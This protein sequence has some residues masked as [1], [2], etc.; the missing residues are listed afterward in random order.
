MEQV[1]FPGFGLTLNISKIA[2]TLFGEDVYWYAVLIA[3]GVAIGFIFLV[4]IKGKN[5]IFGIKSD[6][7]FDALLYTVPISIISGRAYYVIFNFETFKHNLLNIFNFKTGGMAIYGSIIGGLLTLIIF[8]KKRKINTLDLVDYIVP[9][10]ALGQSIGRWGNFF[11]VEA[12]GTETK[13][14][15]RMGIIEKGTYI[16]VH[17]TFLYESIITFCLFIFLSF[18]TKKRKYSGQITY[19]YLFVYA[20]TRFFIEMLRTDSL[21]FYNIRISA[22]VSVAICVIICSILIKNYIND[23]KTEQNKQI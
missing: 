23:K 17:P 20:F 2:F 18:L 6:D 15:W 19:I 7:I 22:I 13:L 9:M 1:T 8:C 4:F 12:Y 11:N 3:F 10:V 16:E 14:P 21:M 5:N